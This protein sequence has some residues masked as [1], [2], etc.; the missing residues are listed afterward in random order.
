QKNQSLLESNSNNDDLQEKLRQ[1]EIFRL[2]NE[3]LRSELETQKK[4][5]NILLRE[6]D[7]LVQTVSKLDSELTKAEYQRISQV[8]PRK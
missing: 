8:Q 2:E 5:K 6:R 1:L 7:S 4:E 3:Q